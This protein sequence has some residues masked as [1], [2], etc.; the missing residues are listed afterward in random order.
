MPLPLSFPSQQN[1]R[2]GAGIICRW[3]TASFGRR[4]TATRETVRLPSLCSAPFCTTLCRPRAAPAA[5]VVSSVIPPRSVASA[6]PNGRAWP[7]ARIA[8]TLNASPTRIGLLN[9]S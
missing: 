3:R 1:C 8:Q 5:G 4:A 7:R 9:Q 6:A 2:L